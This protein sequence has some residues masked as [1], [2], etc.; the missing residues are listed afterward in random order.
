MQFIR[1][2]SEIQVSC[3]NNNN[4]R[5]PH[6]KIHIRFRIQRPINF[7]LGY[8]TQLRFSLQMI[9][10]ATV[11]TGPRPSFARNWITAH[12][13]MKN[14][15]VKRKILPKNVYRLPFHQNAITCVLHSQYLRLLHPIFHIFIP[16]FVKSITCWFCIG[17]IL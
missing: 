9:A 4:S 3:N 2:H 6:H 14:S 16:L 11:I 13:K 7:I 17:T 1:E 15:Q 5:Q 12:R 10:K 8:E